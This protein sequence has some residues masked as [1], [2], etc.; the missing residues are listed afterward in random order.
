MSGKF[1]RIVLIL[2]CL[3]GAAVPQSRTSGGRGELSF[4]VASIK[5]SDPRSTGAAIRSLP[6][7]R[8]SI[9]GI[10]IKNLIF[11]AFHVR[12]DRVV[13][14]PAWLD[15]A[16]YDIEAKPAAGSTSSKGQTGME[17][18]WSRI[19]SLLTD[20]CSL[21]VHYA[22]VNAPVYEL[23]IAPKGLR[24]LEAKGAAPKSG[25]P[26]IILPWSMFISDLEGRLGRPV[27]D[28]T[29]I[30]GNW[31]IKLQYASDDGSP[32]G[33]GVRVDP[34]CDSCQNWPPILAAL[35]DQLGLKAV[36]AKG[37]VDALVI[38]SVSRP[39]EN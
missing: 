3:S 22:T 28:K 30:K 38:D 2:L 31:Y 1:V 18:H 16:R 6:G 24:L 11:L 21:R 7:G 19:R 37:P 12:S 35:Q 13:G 34:D 15:S 33:L 36:S 10:T 4:E 23:Y 8:L 17:E 26:G 27:I 29:A 32:H 39:S 14:A 25:N 9:S 20:R 5:P